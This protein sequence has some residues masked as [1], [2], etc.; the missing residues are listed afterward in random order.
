[1]KNLSIVIVSAL[2]LVLTACGGDDGSKGAGG[3]GGNSGAH[4]LLSTSD[5]ASQYKFTYNRTYSAQKNVSNYGSSTGDQYY[6][7][8]QNSQMYI[9]TV[10]G[11]S[12]IYTPESGG[13]SVECSRTVRPGYA[14]TPA[15]PVKPATTYRPQPV[16][17]ATTY[18]PQPVKPATT[19]QP[20]PVKPVR[21]Y[22]APAPAPVKKY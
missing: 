7:N 8:T 14:G 18:R 13:S 12:D 5:C 22:N 10:S 15:A 6:T 21:T 16:K 1:M 9:K 20:Q 4:I 3:S 2:C 11:N 19:Y 17:P